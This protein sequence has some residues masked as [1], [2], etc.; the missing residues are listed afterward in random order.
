MLNDLAT[1]KYLYIIQ[2]HL[3]LKYNF[4]YEFNHY[5]HYTLFIIYNYAQSLSDLVF[6]LFVLYPLKSNFEPQR[7]F[8]FHA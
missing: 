4:H 5:Q 6:D 2:N 7:N 1:H 8:T 3:I